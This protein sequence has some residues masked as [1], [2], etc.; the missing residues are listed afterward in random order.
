M[1]LELLQW[2]KNGWKKSKDG[3]ARMLKVHFLIP[4]NEFPFRAK[5]EVK[6]FDLTR[7]KKHTQ[8]LL[9]SQNIGDKR[10]GARTKVIMVQ[11]C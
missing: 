11:I 6:R 1:S 7:R 2:Q 9:V 4:A 10:G 3:G 8:T 5:T